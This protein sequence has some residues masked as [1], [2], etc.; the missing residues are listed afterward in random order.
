M[1]LRAY[2]VS[3]LETEL[4]KESHESLGP[5]FWDQPVL[6]FFS[7]EHVPQIAKY[8]PNR[9]LNEAFMWFGAVGLAF[10]IIN[11]WVTLHFVQ[12]TSAYTSR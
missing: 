10:N 12:R 9:G 11:R 4:F 1:S 3:G 5:T 8:I 6:T 7:V 2:T